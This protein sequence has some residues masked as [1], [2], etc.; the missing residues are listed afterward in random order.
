MTLAQ[1]IPNVVPV[2]EYLLEID[3]TPTGASRTW[4][5][6][7]AGFNNISEAL[8]ETIQQ[9][10]FLCGKGFGAN[11]VTGMAPEYTLT[12]VRVLGDSAQ[13]Y[14]FGFTQKFGL[15]KNRETHLRITCT[16][17]ANP[18]TKET[19]SAN[20]TMVNVTDIGGGTTDGSAVSV[21]FRFN[22]APVLGDAWE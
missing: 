9:Y 20:V 8:N 6:L 22:G 1:N 19:I 2:Y 10:F 16:D 15:M 18:E 17:P 7:C 12:G 5:N 3:T 21:S 11:Y 14:V 13:D 4:A